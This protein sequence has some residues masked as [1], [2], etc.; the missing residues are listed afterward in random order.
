MN[1]ELVTNLLKRTVAFFLGLFI[2]QVGVSIFLCMN[3]G[4]DPFTLF[5]QGVSRVL[6]V[7]PGMANRILTFLLLVL[8]LCIDKKEI[9]IGTI[10]AMICAG[11]FLDFSLGILTPLLSFATT[12]PLKIFFYLIGCIT[13][14]I[15]FPILKCADYGVAPNDSVY[16]VMVEKLKKPYGIIRM[17]LDCV[18]M[19]LGFLFGGII[20][21]GTIISIFL[22]G[23]I[24]QVFMDKM[25]PYLYSFLHKQVN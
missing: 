15:G 2:V 19:V 4:S 18:Y 25:N 5:T 3:I 1:T 16:F 22:T 14:A 9:S 6:H 11:N 13:I 12:L 10:L 24:M 7:S 23:P 17:A 20:G 8:V 21:L